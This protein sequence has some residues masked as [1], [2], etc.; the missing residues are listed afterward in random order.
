MTFDAQIDTKTSGELGAAG[1]GAPTFWTLFETKLNAFVTAVNA[2]PSNSTRQI[3]I[4]VQPSA[5]T[6][7]LYRGVVFSIGH[8]TY[9]TM[10]FRFIMNNSATSITYSAGT[11]YTP[12]A[13]NGGTGTITNTINTSFLSSAFTTNQPGDIIT[14]YDDTTSQE[15]FFTN[16]RT[17]SNSYQVY[18]LIFKDTQGDWVFHWG[19]DGSSYTGNSAIAAGYAGWAVQDYCYSRSCVNA[20]FN[21]IP[22]LEFVSSS[23]GA[24]VANPL[25]S[26]TWIRAASP[27]LG[28]CSSS[29][30]LVPYTTA[31]N[32]DWVS[33]GSGIAINL[34]GLIS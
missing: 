2:D 32:Q 7:D 13:A 1:A 12:G 4:L 20:N 34:Q 17:Q 10:N 23:L 22:G 25:A 29:D 31:L 6:S 28:I 30:P 27:K 5:V 9:G 8:P 33:V 3:T 26:K 24:I 18:F 21:V 19:E 16:F 15:F 14:V 11:T